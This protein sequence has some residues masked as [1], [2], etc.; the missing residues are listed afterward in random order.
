[1]PRTVIPFNSGIHE[2][3]DPKLLPEGRLRSVRNL[4][5]R[6][7]GRLGVRF[8]YTA[9]GLDT[10]T[11]VPGS[12]SA[13]ATLTPH[14][15]LTF[16]GELCALG[17]R[18]GAAHPEELFRYLGADAYDWT[19]FLT[20]NGLP[21]A[22]NGR[23]SV[24]PVSH[25]RNLY[26]FPSRSEGS[27]IHLDVAATG[28]SVYAGFSIPDSPQTWFAAFLKDGQHVVTESFARS[29]PRASASSNRIVSTFVAS[30]NVR[31]A[32][33]FLASLP[34][35]FPSGTN[36][37]DS[38]SGNLNA[39]DISAVEGSDNEYWI[40][41]ARDTPAVFLHRVNSVG[42][43]QQTINVGAVSASHVAVIADGTRVHLLTVESGFPQ[44]RTYLASGGTLENGPINPFSGFGFPNTATAREP[45]LCYSE[46][47]SEVAF[48][49]SNNSSTSELLFVVRNAS[50]HS[51]ITNYGTRTQMPGLTLSSK[52]L[53]VNDESAGGPGLVMFAA[54]FEDNAG[55]L[56]NVL[57]AAQNTRL[58]VVQDKLTAGPV[59]AS[60]LPA[61]AKDSS[62]G[63]VY[64]AR[65]VIDNPSGEQTFVPVVSE[66]TV[67]SAER[68]Q[69]VEVNGELFIAGGAPMASDGVF[70]TEAGFLKAP[71][72]LSATPQNGSGS[73]AGSSTHSVVIVEEWTDLQGRVHRSEP[74]DPVT[75]T[76]G[77]SDN[78]IEITGEEG[79]TD[80]SSVDLSSLQTGRRRFNVFCTL[81]APDTQ[82]HAAVQGDEYPLTITL[83]DSDLA[84]NDILYTQGASGAR[85]GPAPFVAPQPARYLAA[86]GDKVLSGGLPERSRIQESRAAF[87]NE[88]ITW[89]ASIGGFRDPRGEVLAVA[90]LDERRIV[91]TATEIVEVPGEGLD[92]NGNGDLGAPRRLP[93]QVGLYGGHLG[94]RSIVETELGLFFQGSADKI[95]VLP[96]GGGAP[97]WI[98]EP[99]QDTLAAFPDISAAVSLR[100]EQTVAFTCNNAAGDDAI[101]LL[102]DLAAQQWLFDDD[103]A[104][105]KSA[106][107]YQGRLVLLRGGSVLQ[108]NDSHPA[109]AFIDTE[110]ILGTLHPFGEGQEGQIDTILLVCEF[111]GDCVVTAYISNDDG[112]TE[113]TLEAQTLGSNGEAFSVGETVVLKWAPT[114]NHVGNRFRIRFTCTED[115]GASEGIVYNYC[116]VHSDS[117]DVSALV[118]DDLKG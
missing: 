72:V 19:P 58:A 16:N 40:A 55:R 43:V 81:D 89:S 63:K 53:K 5:I 80:R 113:E 86:S 18:T 99:V 39:H 12:N 20:G 4:R 111:R 76:L 42:S 51:A 112:A 52:L 41:V 31:F 92:I 74:S 87:L 94:W 34:E 93:S 14:D 104:A 57:G 37:V 29:E 109:S 56:T 13:A 49:E 105:I 25:V 2:E 100:D 85:S 96:R 3:V 44:W 84:D 45:S 78:E 26:R 66:V 103:T 102:Y 97:T 1:M 64:W 68:R 90:S 8:G 101:V 118:D 83:S 28:G 6:R 65:F 22:S 98:S 114:T 50:T 67:N 62:T 106:T 27:P 116:V 48:A 108:Q 79:I 75:V 21:F 73:M 77:A 38:N 82:F 17:S 115:D 46:G 61:L 117:H 54:T 23:V 24:N 91:F 95:F 30:G 47:T 35:G 71:R 33:N 10:F 70:L 11:H 59:S 7:D 36:L 88:P 15:L 60:L 9:L 107:H 69:S 110:V 32:A